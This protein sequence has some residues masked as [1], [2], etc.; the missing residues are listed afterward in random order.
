MLKARKAK[1]SV[2][3]Q[4]GKVLFCGAAAA[5][6]SNF[7]NLL[8]EEDFQSLHIST[9]VLKPQQVTIAMKAMMLSND[10]EIEFKKLSI[11]N[12]IL[13]LWSYIPKEYS[14]TASNSPDTDEQTDI[15]LKE[16]TS[17]SE[18]ENQ[19]VKSES[20]ISDAIT[21]R[22]ELVLAKVNPE[23]KTIPRKPNENVWH[24][25][26]FMDT[27]GQPQ[28]IS[29]LPAV[30]SFAM[31]TFIIHKMT[32]GQKG[33]SEISNVQFGNEK[34]EVSF[35]PHPHN[36]TNLQLIETLMS[37]ASSVLLPDAEY[38]DNLKV[39]DEK[40]TQK[41]ESRSILLVGTHS[42]DDELSID[43]INGI[44]KELEK[45]VERSFID[46]IKPYLNDNYLCLVP[47]DN[48][49]QGKEKA[50]DNKIQDKEKPL[51]NKIQ[52][53]EKPVDKEIQG[54]NTATTTDEKRY[55][56]P[57]IIRSYIR[58]ILNN[59]D[60]I[61]VPIK[62]VLL[63]LEIRKVCQE[64]KCYLIS[65]KEVL[66]LVK[67][68]NLGYNGEFGENDN[69]NDVQFIK[70]GLRF[71]HSFGVLLFFE[72]VEGMKELVI[73]NHQWLFSK[74]TD[75]VCYSFF[76][77]FRQQSD[78]INFETTGIFVK[79]I[80]DSDLLNIHKD[81]EESGI[82][83]ELINPKESFLN[84]LQHLRIAAKHANGYFMPFVLK[85]SKLL[86][87]NVPECNKNIEPLLIQFKSNN[88]KIHFF[89]RG[90]F[91]FLVVELMTTE[92]WK[93]FGQ[94]YV[95]L[96]TL[97]KKDTI[98]YITLID[99]IYC[100]EVCIAHDH[101]ELEQFIIWDI[102][103]S[104][105]TALYR[106]AKQMKMNANLCYGFLCPCLRIENKHISYYATQ[107]HENYSFCYKNVPTKLG[108]SHKVWFSKVCSYI[109]T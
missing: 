58:K 37:Y 19:E 12:E 93:P 57:S 70:Q 31:I 90:A 25:L 99:R 109:T 34:G 73:T 6:K 81:F 104:I 76:Q 27:G 1:Y 60:K 72:E 65:Y 63:E 107:E 66:K 101:E 30:N 51:G 11:D 17:D 26:T 14:V 38:P 56:N 83:T 20:N 106:V 4:Y 7:L 9:E 67:E 23:A 10:G 22:G 82:D 84:L 36:Y 103:Q 47:V 33:L 50:V 43:D 32:G 69:T 28:L 74:L 87:D 96:L 92:E 8:M 89:P 86:E 46:N 18:P 21:E 61:S 16:H 75:I 42:G 108:D 53:K 100:L 13:L 15:T 102:F 3:M 49:I 68:K 5:G 54:K 40:F 24:L 35:E 39:K 71:H 55:T 29:M 41:E 95:N 78:K 94:A 45:V 2:P 85:S 105:N 79:E 98:H 88:S 59:Q 97:I 48:K 44:D 62:W 91:C 77:S 52:G 64:R 80:L